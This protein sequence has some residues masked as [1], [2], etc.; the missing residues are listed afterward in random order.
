MLN[1]LRTSLSKHKIRRFQGIKFDTAL[2]QISV[3]KQARY[4]DY[5]DLFGLGQAI[6]FD[7]KR[8][9]IGLADLPKG[10]RCVRIQIQFPAL[11]IVIDVD[12]LMVT[13]DILSLLSV[14]DMMDNGMD[15][16]VEN[17]CAYHEGRR[18]PLILENY[19]LIHT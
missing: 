9:V 7:W 17:R 5:Y 14:K 16:S 3:I 4:R 12:F 18:E 13:R 8:R 2:N 15:T 10:I 19:F 6:R 11:R 1:T